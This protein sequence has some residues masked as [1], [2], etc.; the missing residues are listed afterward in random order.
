MLSA[1]RRKHVAR[2][3]SFSPY[4]PGAAGDPWVL[5]ARAH[6]VKQSL[7]DEPANYVPF[8][9]WALPL[10]Y[11]VLL[12]FDKLGMVVF[13]NLCF[14]FSP[15]DRE[16]VL[17]GIG[18]VGRAWHHPHH[19]PGVLPGHR[20]SSKSFYCCGHWCAPCSHGMRQPTWPQSKVVWT[21]THKQWPD[22]T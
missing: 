17:T 21:H 20:A 15:R 13:E 1:C 22:V 8:P 19:W 4:L 2:T 5:R 9:V 3:A 11:L 14:A 18:T 10:Q 7:A 6:G 16:W 12:Q